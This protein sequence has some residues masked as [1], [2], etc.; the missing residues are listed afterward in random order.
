LTDQYVGSSNEST[1]VKP[2]AFKDADNGGGC[3]EDD[4]T[5][6]RRCRRSNSIEIDRL[7]NLTYNKASLE[8]I[9]RG[10]GSG[11]GSSDV[12]GGSGYIGSP[13]KP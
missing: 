8:A 3:D 4:F 5:R 1:S 10:S 6:A 13:S 12:I 2:H 9:K 11:S 7:S